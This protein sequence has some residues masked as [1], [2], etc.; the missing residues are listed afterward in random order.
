MALLLWDQRDARL[1]RKAAVVANDY[2]VP[3][4]GEGLRHRSD[5]GLRFRELQS[6]VL[7]EERCHRSLFRLRGLPSPFM[8]TRSRRGADEEEEV[9]RIPKGKHD[10]ASM[11][12]VVIPGMCCP[13]LW[14][15]RV[16]PLGRDSALRD[17]PLVSLLDDA[18][19]DIREQG[20]ENSALGRAGIATDECAVR[21]NACLEECD[22]QAVH[23][24]V[25]DPAAYPI[26]QA[27]VADVV[28]APFDVS[29]HD[30]LVWEPRFP[31]FLE[32]LGSQ[33]HP[34]MLQRSV[35]RLSRSEAVRDGEEVRLEHRLQDVLQCCLNHPVFR[36]GNSQGAKLPALVTV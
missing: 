11:F 16:A 9:I 1:P 20:R 17:M 26:H 25:S 36:G 18:E 35:D 7:L 5:E 6:Q 29:L 23:L 2:V 30:P 13:S 22:D 31:T 27:M 10:R 24:R 8:L 15:R 32:I 14:Q 4:E 19:G 28:E 3:K 21:E 12:P 33:Q 34:K